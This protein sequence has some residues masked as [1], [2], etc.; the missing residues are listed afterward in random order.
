MLSLKALRL[1]C[2]QKTNRDPVVSFG[3]N[4]VS[5]ALDSLRAK[6]LARSVSGS[7]IV[8]SRARTRSLSKNR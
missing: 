7:R 4:Q 3:E 6:K 8:W 5:E 2:N 1:A